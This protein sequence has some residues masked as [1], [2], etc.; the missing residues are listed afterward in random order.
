MLYGALAQ[1]YEIP[2]ERYYFA[3]MAINW[4]AGLMLVRRVQSR[5]EIPTESGDSLI[6]PNCTNSTLSLQTG[7]AYDTFAGRWW[8]SEGY[9]TN[10]HG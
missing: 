1:K 9:D 10:K 8:R 7:I 2:R 5:G 6:D 3:N 4:E